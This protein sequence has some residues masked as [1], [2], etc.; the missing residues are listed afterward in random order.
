MNIIEMKDIRVAYD[1]RAVLPDISLDVKRGEFLAI[2][3]PNGGGKTTLLRVMLKLLRPD[4]GSVTYF[5][6]SGHTEK[7]LAIGYLPQKSNIDTR[8]PITVGQVV[9]SGLRRHIFQRSTPE[10]EDRFREIVEL[11]GIG[12]YLDRSVGVLSGGQLQRTLLGRALISAPEL[13][14]LD[15]P[16]SYVDATFEHQIYSIMEDVAHKSTIVLV[17]HQMSVISEMATRHV[18]VDRGLH[19]CSSHKHGIRTCENEAAEGRN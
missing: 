13:V 11:M 1:G 2:S 12:D 8:F 6:A 4:K 19:D 5:N 16:L 17:S 3:G 15:E 14:V 7:R 9:R 10:D 18:I